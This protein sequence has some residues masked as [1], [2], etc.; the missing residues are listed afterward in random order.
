[1]E[2]L[3]GGNLDKAAG[4]KTKFVLTGVTEEKRHDLE[5]EFCEEF[6][7]FFAVTK[8]YAKLSFIYRVVFIGVSSLSLIVFGLIML[9]IIVIASLVGQITVLCVF[10]AAFFA[11]FILKTV[12]DKRNERLLL[13][14]KNFQ[15]WLKIK[16]GI[17]YTVNISLG[18]YKK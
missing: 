12:L 11:V 4:G 9:N 18:Y 17:G 13:Y 2:R 10:L 3:F 16:K 8:R 5:R 7:Q 14:M 6:P 15:S 1:M